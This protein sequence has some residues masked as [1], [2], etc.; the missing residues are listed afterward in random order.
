MIKTPPFPVGAAFDDYVNDQ[1]KKRQE[2]QYSGF[3]NKRTDQQLSYLTNRLSFIKLASSVNIDAESGGI[4]KLLQLQGITEKQAKS[5]VGN[6]L[7]QDYVLSN[8]LSKYNFPLQRSG[9]SNTNNVLNA[10]NYGTLGTEFGLQAM[11]G[12]QSATITSINDGSTREATIQIRAN[13]PQQFDIIEL[14]YLRL[15]HTMLIEWGH[16][17]YV[18]TDGKIKSLESTLID[19]GIWFDPKPVKLK[20]ETGEFEEVNPLDFNGLIRLIQIKTYQYR[21]NYGGFY[22]N[23]KNFSWDFRPEG[24]YIITINLISVGAVVESLRADRL[25]PGTTIPNP[26]GE[27]AVYE[28]ESNQNTLL[29]HLYCLRKDLADNR[30]NLAE[31]NSDYVSVTGLEDEADTLGDTIKEIERDSTL[32]IRFGELLSWIESNLCVH[33]S[34]DGDNYFPMLE[35]NVSDQNYFRIF[36]GLIS[37]NPKICYIENDLPIYKEKKV[38]SD[39]VERDLTKYF[40]PVNDSIDN[41]YRG[42]ITNLYINFKHIENCIK[43]QGKLQDSNVSIFTFLKKLLDGVNSCFAGYVNLIP[44]LQDDYIVTIRDKK[45]E[46]RTD[47]KGD[48]IVSNEENSSQEIKLFGF[49]T[50]NKQ[51]SFVKDFSFVTKLDNDFSTVISVGAVNGNNT[52]VEHADF[53]ENFNS[54]LIDRYKKEAEE[55]NPKKDEKYTIKCA[56]D[57]KEKQNKTSD[58]LKTI[59]DVFVNINIIDALKNVFNPV[60]VTTTAAVNK[61]KTD[62]NIQIPKPTTY[63]LYLEHLVHLLGPESGF[64]S[65]GGNHAYF[66]GKP[67]DIGKS[68]SLLSAYINEATNSVVQKSNKKLKSSTLGIVPLELNMT[69]DGISGIKIY[70]QLVVDTKFLPKDYQNSTEFSIFGQE[71]RIQDNQWTTTLRANTAPKGNLMAIGFDTGEKVSEEEQVAEVRLSD[72]EINELRYPI[73]SDNNREIVITSLFGLRQSP[74]SNFPHTKQHKG[75]DLRASAG[76]PMFPIGNE[77]KVTATGFDETLGNFVVMETKVKART[78]K[79]QYF[80]LQSPPPVKVGQSVGFGV[81]VGYVGSSGSST[82][83]HVHMKVQINGALV[84]PKAVLPLVDS[85]ASDIKLILKEQTVPGI[86]YRQIAP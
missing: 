20:N 84:D 57:E 35:F 76:T 43:S 60:G 62:N 68:K 22:G 40:K 71:H 5:L 24:Y 85:F 48:V 16:N 69:V 4:E 6:K 80:H 63:D 26:T 28:S 15:G 32:Y 36:P 45:L 79:V 8:G 39:L 37:T 11:P 75:L 47:E 41:K 13:S 73:A 17:R 25:I 38:G 7:A 61:F 14:L 67:E 30:F 33:F 10:S 1:I 54:G 81:R 58:A 72:E 42:Q 66:K 55:N 29:N 86:V 21:G 49:D 31:N 51:T 64:F 9:V 52:S 59:A 19:D 12:I 44:Q 70:N 34:N 46:F 53:F 3:E 50:Q 2:L 82:A 78:F 18:D 27:K 74:T 77:T 83:P 56:K 65:W 23:V